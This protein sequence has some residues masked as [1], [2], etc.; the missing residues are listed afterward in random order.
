MFPETAAAN[1]DHYQP[2]NTCTIMNQT[3]YYNYAMLLQSVI[4]ASQ[5]LPDISGHGRS[6][7]KWIFYR[8]I[9]SFLSSNQQH[10]STEE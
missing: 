1:S 10:Q 4:F 8:Q 7:K 5:F 3:V 9:W 2:L 6:P